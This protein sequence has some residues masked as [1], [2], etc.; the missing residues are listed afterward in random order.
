MT[1]TQAPAIEQREN[2]RHPV[3]LAG[4][5]FLPADG[6][7]FDCTVTNL[8]A[9][10]AGFW[11]AAPSPLDKPIVLYV[12]GFGRFEGVA[13]RNINGDAGLRFVCQPA[14]RKRLEEALAAF[15][16]DGMKA[17]T[18]LRRFERAAVSVGTD[19]FTLAD[20]EAVPCTLV[21]ISLQG[22]S[23]KTARRPAVGTVVY[24]GQTKSWVVR[25]DHDG[26][27]VQFLQRAAA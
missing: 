2:Q 18:R 23:L 12:D 9:G 17:V 11:C 1:D 16:M 15:V 5:I 4:K 10:G 19:H 22:A 7:T 13:V 27:A 8:S 3:C 14:K 26:I 20:G 25:H 24:L 21:D 6:A